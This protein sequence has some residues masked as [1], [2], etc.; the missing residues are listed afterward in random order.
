MGRR[1]DELPVTHRDG[2][3]KMTCPPISKSKANG[4]GEYHSD[5]VLSGPDLAGVVGVLEHSHMMVWPRTTG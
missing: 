1:F 4:E 3:Y 5:V 2:A